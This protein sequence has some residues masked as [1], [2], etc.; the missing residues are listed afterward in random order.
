MQTVIKDKW[1]AEETKDHPGMLF[2]GDFSSLCMIFVCIIKKC[3]FLHVNMNF[4]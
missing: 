1:I 3:M 2:T 4:T